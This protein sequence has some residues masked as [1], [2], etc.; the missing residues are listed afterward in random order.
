MDA[1]NNSSDSLFKEIER[2]ELKLDDVV[3]AEIYWVDAI[4]DG[5]VLVVS[6]S[7]YGNNYEILK[8]S[9]SGKFIKK[10]DKRGNGPG[11]LRSIHNI[12]V[13]DKSI[14]VPEKS[15]P[16]IHEFSHHLEFI[17]DHRIKTGG[18]G[19]LLGNYI[20]ILS[21][22]FKKENKKDK[23]FIL[24]LYDRN[25][26]EFKKLAFEIPE[27][28]AFV[29]LWGS[30]CR[31]DNNTIAGVYPILYSINLFDAEMNLKRVIKTEF[32]GHFKKYYP[33]KKSPSV[34]DESGI[35]WMHSWVKLHSVLYVNGKFIITYL[36][37]KKCF[38]DIISIDG[39][40]LVSTVELRK[41]RIYMFA[42]GPSIWRLEENDDGTKHTLVKEIIQLK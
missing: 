3:F 7:A 36:Q 22:N 34:V 1:V 40:S 31:V 18:N 24:A 10:Y 19:F 29:H 37:N 16:Y 5:F 11:E 13:L 8:I 32:P 33:W 20:G 38:Y 4:P 12:I 35:K 26:F 27:V 30:F 15:A 2:V 25:T 6:E 42:E 9:R 23:I 21:L 28:P 41:N 14:L 39:K 17:R